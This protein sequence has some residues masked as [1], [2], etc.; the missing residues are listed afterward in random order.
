MRLLFLLQSVLDM[1]PQGCQRKYTTL[2][3]IFII[4]HLWST[5]VQFAPQSKLPGPGNSQSV[6]IFDPLARFDSKTLCPEFIDQLASVR[7]KA[8]FGAGGGALKSG[9]AS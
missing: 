8:S 2:T 7:E 5:P 4:N 6:C 3:M 9:I 1:C